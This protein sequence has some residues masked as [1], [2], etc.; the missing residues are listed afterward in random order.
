MAPE[1]RAE[2]FAV[3]SKC[4]FSHPLSVTV[5]KARIIAISNALIFVTVPVVQESA[6]LVTPICGDEKGDLM[7][8]D[9]AAMVDN[10]LRCVIM[11]VLVCTTHRRPQRVRWKSGLSGAVDKC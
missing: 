3:T 9:I 4:F 2:L 1:C 7:D 11:R 8:V 6:R 10:N 5:G